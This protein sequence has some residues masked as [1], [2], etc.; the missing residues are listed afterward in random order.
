MKYSSYLLL[1]EEYLRK[2]SIMVGVIPFLHSI[3]VPILLK[4]IRQIAQLTAFLTSNSSSNSS[5]FNPSKVYGML[6]FSS[7]EG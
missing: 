6:I 5:F 4:T 3:S 7:P 1:R 2:D